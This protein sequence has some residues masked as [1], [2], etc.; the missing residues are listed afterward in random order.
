MSY[1]ARIKP[2]QKNCGRARRP[3]TLLDMQHIVPGQQ[4]PG[5]VMLP[6][7]RC[8]REEAIHLSSYGHCSTQLWSVL[9]QPLYELSTHAAL[10]CM[11]FG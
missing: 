6:C 2:S 5:V 4:G 1:E 8:K 11:M 3:I 7:R 10:Q 9:A